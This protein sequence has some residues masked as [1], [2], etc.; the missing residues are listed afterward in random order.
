MISP[1]TAMSPAVT[2]AGNQGPPGKLDEWGGLAIDVRRS[3]LAQLRGGR[4]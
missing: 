3:V 4:A 1:F 2:P